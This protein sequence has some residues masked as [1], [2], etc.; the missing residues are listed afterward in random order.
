MFKGTAK[1]KDQFTTIIDTVIVPGT[2]RLEYLIVVD[3]QPEWVKETHLEAIQMNK[4]VIKATM[5]TPLKG[6]FAGVK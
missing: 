1:Y 5:K 4:T 6:L 3:G 2:F